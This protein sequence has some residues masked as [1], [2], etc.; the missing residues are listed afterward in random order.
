MCESLPLNQRSHRMLTSEID[1]RTI[2]APSG[3][4]T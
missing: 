1:I 4:S 2:E 3:Q